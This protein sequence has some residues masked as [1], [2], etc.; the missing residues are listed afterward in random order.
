MVAVFITLT[1]GREE[2]ILA[3]KRSLMSI[4][5]PKD[6]ESPRIKILRLLP[7]ACAISRWPFSSVLMLHASPAALISVV[8]RCGLLL[9]PVCASERRSRGLGDIASIQSQGCFR[10][11]G[12]HRQNA[13]K[14][15]PKNRYS[16]LSMLLYLGRAL[17]DSQ[18]EMTG[19]S[20]R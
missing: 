20:R 2:S 17:G 16:H 12:R 7:G 18:S 13:K 6:N 1:P 11:E 8:K 10:S 9:H 14:S 3:S 19:S 4:P 5:S 15:C